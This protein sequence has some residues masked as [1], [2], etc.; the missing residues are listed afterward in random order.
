MPRSLLLKYKSHHLLFWM[1]VFGTW[2][3]FRAGDYPTEQMALTVTLVKVLD[4]ALTVYITNY[5]LIPFLLYRKRYVLFGVSLLLLVVAT[6][7]AKMQL[8]LVVTGFSDQYNLSVSL[9][10]RIYDNIVPHFFL[11]I[12]GAAFRLMYDYGRLQKRMAET[13][14]EKA[15]AE[16]SF[17]KS[18]INPHFLFNSLNAVYFLIDRNNEE[19]RSALHRFSDMLRHQLY[20]TGADRIPVEKEIHYLQDYVALQKLRKDD[21]YEVSFRYGG[22]LSEIRIEPFLLLPFVENAF[23]Y[24]SHSRE[25]INFIRFDLHRQNGQLVFTAENSRD[26]VITTD[27]DSSGIGIANV[28]RRLELLYPNAHQL[29]IRDDNETYSVKLSLKLN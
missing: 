11:V 28:R 20:G 2:Y 27:P 25:K 29:Q 5:L 15:E 10:A 6:S 3:F 12:A 13:A 17:L 18:Q 1:L 19:A 14:R 16:L 7:L 9:R 4:L 8:L 21:R 23:K 24:V 26:P 22:D